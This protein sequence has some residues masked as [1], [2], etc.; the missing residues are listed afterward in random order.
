MERCERGIWWNAT[1]IITNCHSTWMVGDVIKLMVNVVNG[2]ERTS[3]RRFCGRLKIPV[4]VGRRSD[5]VVSVE[6]QSA[7]GWT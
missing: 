6:Q 1:G 5:V 4:Y 3:R 2:G 7:D